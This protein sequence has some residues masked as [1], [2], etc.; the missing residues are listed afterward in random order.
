MTVVKRYRLIIVV[1][2]GLMLGVIAYLYFR[3]PSIH[4]EE[5]SELLIAREDGKREILLLQRT[6]LMAAIKENET[7]LL[8]LQKITVAPPAS[9]A[10]LNMMG[11]D[12]IAK[13]F[14]ESGL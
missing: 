8:Q 14:T 3:T 13:R 2:L 1:G 12:E 5:R 6:E 4:T 10:I 9:S 11:D 7:K